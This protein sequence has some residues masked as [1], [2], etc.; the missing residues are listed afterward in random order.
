VLIAYL[1]SSSRVQLT[2]IPTTTY[3]TQPRDLSD[4]LLLDVETGLGEKSS[5]IEEAI[6]AVQSFVRRARLGLEPG[7]H[8]GYEFAR[9]WESRFDTYHTWE[10]S[11]LRELY[12]EN[13]ITW[14]E[15]EKAHRMEAFRSSSPSCAPRP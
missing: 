2:W 12:K 11:K 10:R 9:L 1:Y 13:W 8:I 7:W 5:R 4:L 6:S 15:L 14:S 3:A